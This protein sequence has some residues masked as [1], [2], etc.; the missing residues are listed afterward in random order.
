MS[1]ENISTSIPTKTES[2]LYAE[3]C[4]QLDLNKIKTDIT[5]SPII[6]IDPID[7]DFLHL[8]A[9][10]LGP[11]ETPYENGIFLLDIKLPDQY[12]VR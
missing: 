5:N 10:I 4:I 3:K 11:T 9:G 1:V 7:D 2:S 8:E 6:F 12:P